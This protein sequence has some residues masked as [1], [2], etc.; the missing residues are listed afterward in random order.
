MNRPYILVVD[1][2]AIM[3]KLM[4]RYLDINGYEAQSVSDGLAC[5][6]HVAVRKPD[7]ILT[8]VMMPRLDGLRMTELLREDATTRDIPVIVITALSDHHTQVRAIEVG[9]TDVM[10]KPIDEP[11]LIAKIRLLVAAQQAT[12]QIAALRAV[13]AAYQRGDAELAAEIFASLEGEA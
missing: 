5:I 2:N 1:D 4:C 12:K 6:E 3:A 13:I 9:G 8:D 7:V 11:V 10:A